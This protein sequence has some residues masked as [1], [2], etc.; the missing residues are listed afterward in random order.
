MV[1]G[2]DSVWRDGL[3]SLVDSFRKESLSG[4]EPYLTV[5]RRSVWR[6]VLGAGVELVPVG[7][8]GDTG[9][10][11]SVGFSGWPLSTSPAVVAGSL[12][13]IVPNPATTARIATTTGAIIRK[14]SG[15]MRVW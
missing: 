14:Y 3:E 11:V 7:E 13:P 15:G 6:F 4:T 2:I 12:T 5:P 8:S 10:L 9:V 1:N